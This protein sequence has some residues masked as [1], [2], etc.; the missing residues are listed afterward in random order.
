MPWQPAGDPAWHFVKQ[1]ASPQV[2]CGSAE[3]LEWCFKSP[4]GDSGFCCLCKHLELE[5]RAEKGGCWKGRSAGDKTLGWNLN[6]FCM[7]SCKSLSD[8]RN[9]TKGKACS[10]SQSCGVRECQG[11]SCNPVALSL[12]EEAKE[13]IMNM[14]VGW[15]EPSLI[16]YPTA[17]FPSPVFCSFISKQLFPL[18]ILM[19]LWLLLF[20][21]V[22]QR[23]HQSNIFSYFP[24]LLVWFCSKE[25]RSQLVDYYLHSWCTC[26]YFTTVCNYFI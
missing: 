24:Y 3:M 22:Y 15:L 25:N 18:V 1:N 26:I 21:S 10:L 4:L 9:F 7:R 23:D 14:A 2:C 5:S 17:A 12:E 19:I 20:W 16:V 11:T 8:G 6:W 13:C